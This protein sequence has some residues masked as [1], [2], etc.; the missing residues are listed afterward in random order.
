M[1]IRSGL[2]LEYVRLGM[3]NVPMVNL[4]GI[5]KAKCE[6]VENLTGKHTLIAIAHRL[7]TVRKADRIIV[8][9]DGR[10]AEEGTH[11]ELVQLGGIYAGMCGLH[12]TDARIRTEV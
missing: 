6:I 12:D 3:T 7:S 9:K 8:L 2:H 4:V 5:L 10:I 11:E 1:S